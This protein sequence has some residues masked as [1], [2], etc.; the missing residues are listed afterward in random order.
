[1]AKYG[2]PAGVWVGSFVDSI[3][4]WKKMRGKQNQATN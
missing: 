4:N 1:M 2:G 3:G